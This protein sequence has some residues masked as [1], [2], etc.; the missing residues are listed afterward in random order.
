MTKLKSLLFLAFSFLS[1]A[2]F[3]QDTAQ[4]EM[5]DV[6]FQSGKIYVVVVVLSIIFV[7]IIAYMV[8]LDKKITKL[9]KE[10]KNK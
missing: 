10:L 5:A 1:I 4:V 3:A 8:M 9:E 7:G 2:G 6:L